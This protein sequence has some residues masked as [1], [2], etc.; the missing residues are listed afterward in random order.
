MWN[1]P[2][3][4]VIDLSGN[5]IA[6]EA[7]LWLVELCKSAVSLE[8]LVLEDTLLQDHE[9]FHLNSILERNMKFHR[10][11]AVSPNT[12][13]GSHAFQPSTSIRAQALK[14]DI[15]GVSAGRAASPKLGQVS[16]AAT[17]GSPAKKTGGSHS[18]A[19]WTAID[20]ARRKSV[21][22]VKSLSSQLA[23]LLDNPQVRT[24]QKTPE[25]R[26][27]LVSMLKTSALYDLLL[28]PLGASPKMKE[29]IDHDENLRVLS[30]EEKEVVL[31]Q[32]QEEA[33]RVERVNDTIQFIAS[34]MLKATYKD[35][36][37]VSEAGD[38]AEWVFFVGNGG[39]LF[40]EP[41]ADYSQSPAARE[42][43]EGALLPL[44]YGEG[45]FC[46]E[47]ELMLDDFGSNW[48]RRQNIIA[49]TNEGEARRA[50]GAQRATPPPANA[51][52]SPAPGDRSASPSAA[53]T[54]ASS[55][56]GSVHNLKPKTPGSPTGLQSISNNASQ[57]GSD[58]EEVVV[59][60][61]RREVFIQIFVRE[62]TQQRAAW[63]RFCDSVP[64]FVGL[65]GYAKMRLA[66]GLHKTRFIAGETVNTS[67]KENIL[68][69]VDG[70]LAIR[71]VDAL[72]NEPR[73]LIRGEVVA[74]ADLMDET[75]A[76][77][78]AQSSTSIPMSGGS[79]ANAEGSPSLF[80][81]PLATLEARYPIEIG[82]QLR[83][84]RKMWW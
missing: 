26:D 70:A 28:P 54:A 12:P 66:D 69:V 31:Q 43:R 39:N 11:S 20:G 7:Y 53:N 77:I 36:E 17:I 79:A 71:N 45:C 49:R 60:Q 37:V 33:K 67:P 50:S 32:R 25:E 24:Y 56:A 76:S 78:V 47:Q 40:T 81:L 29:S 15:F 57:T 5:E 51:A 22:G 27:Y 19:E 44:T 48:V 30:F 74:F 59:W 3:I 41:P 68:I 14:E 1:H 13:Q 65:T 9:I 58:S 6:T 62:L 84:Q 63:R 73:S 38:R 82:Q 8:K 16:T 18:A 75:S 4:K 34:V 42:D 52:R 80:I 35:G 46:G 61:L 23:A 72:R 55:P 64:A 2:S 21:E 83:K 10:G